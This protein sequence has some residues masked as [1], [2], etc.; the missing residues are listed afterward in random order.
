MSSFRDTF[1]PQLY[2]LFLIPALAACGN[3][4]YAG[5]SNNGTGF[6]IASNNSGSCSLAN[7]MGKMGATMEKTVPCATCT[8]AAR[9]EHAFVTVRG[10]SIRAAS[11]EWL[12]LAPDL[13]TMPRQMDLVGNNA[14][15]VLADGAA[16]AAGSYTEARVEFANNAA[17]IQTN[18]C[19]AAAR[20]CL[21]FGDGRLEPLRFADGPAAVTVPL[22]NDAVMVVPGGRVNINVKLQTH[23]VLRAS[24]IG[25]TTENVLAGTATVTR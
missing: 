13:A 24:E 7:G 18:R 17:N 2:L 25:I 5:F 9:V 15:E 20:N 22:A 11:G 4:C 3:S 19:G 21:Q 12:E 14:P 6:I 23:P 10:I 8:A 1:L 16:L